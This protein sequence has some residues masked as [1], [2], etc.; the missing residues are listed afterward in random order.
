[1]RARLENLLYSVHKQVAGKA[2]ALTSLVGQNL[3]FLA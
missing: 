1:M 2:R 3:R